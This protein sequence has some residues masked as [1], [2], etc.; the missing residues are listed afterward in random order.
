MWHSLTAALDKDPGERPGSIHLFVESFIDAGVAEGLWHKDPIVDE[1][2]NVVQTLREMEL[3]VIDNRQ[4]GGALWV[5][6]DRPLGTLLRA[7]EPRFT[8]AENGGLASGGRAAWWTNW[9]RETLSELRRPG[10]TG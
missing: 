5:V 7:L 1:Y 8:F 9:G 10:L 2:L 3:E 6:G 4:N